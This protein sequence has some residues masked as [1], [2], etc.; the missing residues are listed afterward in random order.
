M[1]K[2]P[3]CPSKEALLLKRKRARATKKRERSPKRQAD[4]DRSLRR[5]K[6]NRE[7]SPTRRGNVRDRRGPPQHELQQRYSPQQYA[8]LT[9][10]MSQVL[11]EVQHERFLR[12]PSQ[13]KSNPDKRDDTK[14]CEFHKD[15]GHRTDHYIQLKKEIEYLIRRGHL[16]RYVASKGQVANEP[17]SSG[18]EQL[19][20]RELN[21]SEK[22]I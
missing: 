3:S 19:S 13:M 11:R 1:V 8:P 2:K 5:S 22:A 16:G 17:C 12:W 18:A 6:E 14:Y 9:A 4:R 7:R 21:C 10:S 15:H 20:F